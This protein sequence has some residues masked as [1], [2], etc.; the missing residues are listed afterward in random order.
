MFG[1]H[2]TYRVSSFLLVMCVNLS[3]CS[4][5]AADNVRTYRDREFGFSFVY[6]AT[7]SEQPGIGRNTRVVITAPTNQPQASCNIIVRRVSGI[8]KQNQDQLN[9]GLDGKEF[10]HDYWLRDMPK[11]TRVFDA[12]RISLGRHV[13][14]SAV[15]DF[16]ATIQGYT[17]YATQL[18]L[19]TLSPGLFFGFT[20]GSQ[21]DTP[22][23]A[24]ASYTFWK[25]T[26]FNIVRSLRLKGE[27]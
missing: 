10:E 27:K 5:Y 8:A 23:E 16:S 21:G 2:N 18:H 11:N 13:A 22:K 26:F 6:P 9:R 24:R 17:G 19:V 25:S 7:W 20:C 3:A 12:Q 4:V 15:L 1:F 14:R